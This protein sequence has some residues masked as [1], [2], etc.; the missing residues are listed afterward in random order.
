MMCLIMS[1]YSLG[2][3]SKSGIR[4]TAMDYELSLCS[5]RHDSMSHFN[6]EKQTTTK[7]RSTVDTELKEGLSLKECL[8][9]FKLEASKASLHYAILNVKP[10]K[11]QKWRWFPKSA[12]LLGLSHAV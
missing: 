2:V 12:V 1:H 7:A 5:L 9:V 10:T 11:M 8:W 3:M 6:E 4:S